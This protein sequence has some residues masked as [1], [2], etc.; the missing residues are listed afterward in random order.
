M[1]KRKKSYEFTPIEF[2]QLTTKEKNDVR[3]KATAWRTMFKEHVDSLVKTA[4]I[5]YAPCG[6]DL[7]RP[8]LWKAAHWNWF[9]SEVSRGNNEKNSN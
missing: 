6:Q 7:F 5:A 4:Q 3:T 8:E 9:L 1:K 2:W